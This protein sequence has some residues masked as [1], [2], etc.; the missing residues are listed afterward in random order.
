MSDPASLPPSGPTPDTPS[1]IDPGLFD[2]VARARGGA[3]AVA[4]LGRGQVGKRM[5]LAVAVRRGLAGGGFEGDFL[6]LSELR[7]EDPE[8]WLSTMLHPYLDE[9]LARA[10]AEVA[11][12]GRPDLG[13]FGELVRGGPAALSGPLVLSSR[14]DGLVLRLRLDDRGPFRAVHGHPPAGAQTPDEVQ[15][16]QRLLDGAWEVL[17]RR[18]PW[19]ARAVA[20]CLTTL[21]PLRPGPGGTSVSS[22]ARR[23]YG[24]VALSPPGDPVLLALTL[25]HEFL[26]VQLGALLDLVPLHGPPTPAR[27]DAPWRPDPRPLDALLQGTYAHLGVCDFWHTELA[28]AEPDPRAEQE[29]TTWY[30]HTRTAVDTLLRSGEL[31]P[32]GRRFAERMRHALRQPRQP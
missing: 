11:Q 4:V 8:R 10:L 13:W 20:A 23:A 30:G 18:H 14:C 2:A 31:L 22:A 7:R 19:H 6:R 26:H 21:V 9:G 5:L 17:V 3:G 12:G 29:H 25:V 32:P 1:A 16:W 24:A 15:H 27:Y 28:A